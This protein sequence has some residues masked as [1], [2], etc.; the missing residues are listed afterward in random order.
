MAEAVY[1]Q[2]ENVAALLGLAFSADTRPTRDEVNDFLLWAEAEVERRTHHAWQTRTAVK[3]RHDYPLYL[4]TA[5]DWLDGIRLKLL[6]RELL[7]TAAAD[8]TEILSTAA[9][10]KLE[11][12]NGSSW[13]DWT[14]TQTGG[15]SGRHWLD[16]EKGILFLKSF[17]RRHK[18]SAVRLT[19]RFGGGPWLQQYGG[20]SPNW[21]IPPDIRQATALLAAIQ[22]LQADLFT[23]NVPGGPDINTN[24]IPGKIRDFGAKVD[25]L[26]APHIEVFTV[27]G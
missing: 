10:D 17:Y 25:R 12:W 27:V 14:V 26:L 16:P 8:G 3:E 5:R 11:I 20:I 6:H 4:Y 22:V 13:E 21:Q 23:S 2:A 1:A 24:P 9:G 18:I 15:H 7:F 19:Y